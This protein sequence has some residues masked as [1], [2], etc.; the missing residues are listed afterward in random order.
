MTTIKLALD[1]FINS[2]HI[3]IIVAQE[4]NWLTDSAI[5]LSLV[6]PQEDHYATDTFQ[7][8]VN[9]KVDIAICPPEQLIEAYRHNNRECVA[10]ASLLQPRATGFA[11][12]PN[13]QPVYA[14]LELPY[15]SYI[16]QQV[17]KHVKIADPQV[18]IVPKLDTW[19]AFKSGQASMCWIF[20]PW[21]GAEMETNAISGEYISLHQA[22]VPYPNCPLLVCKRNWAHNN[23]SLI[24]T[25]LHAVGAG[26]GFARD[27][28]REAIHILKLHIPQRVEFHDKMLFK[29]M[30]ATNQVSLDMFERWGI[31]QVSLFRQYIGWLKE[32]AALQLPINPEE[33]LTNE[34]LE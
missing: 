16:V 13:V 34:F 22:G 29:A 4:K 15:E 5:K 2:L 7:K 20:Q 31:L 21:E 33:M 26:F 19:E 3:G 8:L 32:N 12:R 9:G 28:I 23:R 25:F 27:H 24:R 18:Q 10:I 1:W 14:A 11:I 17:S 6:S 30:V